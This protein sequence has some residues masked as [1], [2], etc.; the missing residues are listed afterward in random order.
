[1]S[2][3]PTIIDLVLVE[4]GSIQRLNVSGMRTRI[5]NMIATL[6]AARQRAPGPPAPEP[7]PNMRRSPTRCCNVPW[8]IFPLR[9]EVDIAIEG[10]PADVSRRD[11]ARIFQWLET[12]VWEEDGPL[13]PPPGFVQ[14]VGAELP[15]L[16]ALPPHDCTAAVM[17]AH[18]LWQEEGLRAGKREMLDRLDAFLDT[19]AH[20]LGQE[21]GLRAGKREMLNR[22]DAFL[23]T[24]G[25]Q[26]QAMRDG[27]LG[28][29]DGLAEWIADQ[30]KS[31]EAPPA[32]APVEEG[33]AHVG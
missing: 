26:R 25:R 11:V 3:E 16:A 21:E 5:G 30:R 27:P 31:L 9:R 15:A 29:I 22:L 33:V 6:T 8:L 13:V 12:F 7:R 14:A 1:M 19:W 32:P 10:L 2:G 17:Q 18:G 4:L 28:P 23:D 24:W 20:G